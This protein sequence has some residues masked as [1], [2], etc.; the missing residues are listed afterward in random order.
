MNYIHEHPDFNLFIN[1]EN[2]CPQ[3]HKL[4]LFFPL[5]SIKFVSNRLLNI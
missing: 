5:L 3:G 2:K 4:F 1:K